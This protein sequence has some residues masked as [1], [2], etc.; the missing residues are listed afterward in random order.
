MIDPEA[1]RS[2]FAALADEA[3]P[4]ERIR[5]S[6]AIRAQRHRQRRL[7][8]RLAGAGA[9]AGAAG[10]A[11]VG[12]W[13]FTRP[14][15]PEFPVLTGGPGGGWL[16]VPL[17]YRPGWLPHSYGEGS[18]AVVVDGAAAPVISRDWQPG[19]VEEMISL[20]VGWHP[21]LEAD[22]PR[23]QQTTVDVNGVTGQL[24]Q[25]TGRAVASYL[26]WQP[27]GQPQLMVSML[28]ADDAQAQRDLIVRVARSVRP[29][30]AVTWVGP[31]FGWLPPD[32]A[33]VPWRLHQGFQ[34]NHWA[35]DVTVVGADGRQ[36]LLR[37]GTSPA[38]R[39]ENT[40]PTV[41]IRIRQWNGWQLP[42]HRQLFLTM[43]DGVEVFAQLD[44][45]PGGEDAMAALI[46]I[47]EQFEFGPW[48][49]L[50]WIGAR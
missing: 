48:P 34:D 18:R 12:G 30:P 2:A 28:T 1:V 9:V 21:S 32:L 17:R 26:S 19:P 29:D 27:P 42:E 40:F 3:P 10:V 37:M 46:R 36:L 35:Q 7:V 15:A 47:M 24:V 44:N 50:S 11:A 20:L 43:P 23:G 39:L 33:A 38:A 25:V 5:A 6:L 49:D 45:A 31:R 22:R 13:R 8:L 41:P 16:E 4:P 14:S